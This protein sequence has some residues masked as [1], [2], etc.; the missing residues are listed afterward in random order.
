MA[1]NAETKPRYVMPTGISLLSN[2]CL[3]IMGSHVLGKDFKY[4][5]LSL[6]RLSEALTDQ[7]TLFI[8]KASEGGMFGASEE[9]SNG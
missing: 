7:N 1:S 9:L 3:E 5:E 2:K 4:D 8:T 6:Y